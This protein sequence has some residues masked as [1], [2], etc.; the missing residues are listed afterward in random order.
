MRV[1]GVLLC[2]IAAAMALQPPPARPVAGRRGRA[3]LGVS[4]IEGALASG[5]ADRVVAAL[6]EDN[7]ETTLGRGLAAACLDKACAVEAASDGQS[8]ATALASEED[9][10]LRCYVAL[11]ERGLCGRFG[12]GIL[13][14]WPVTRRV[15]TPEFIAARTGNLTLASFAPTETVGPLWWVLGSILSVGEILLS[16]ALGLESPQP[17]FLATAGLVV[18]DQIA[19]R[20]AGSEAVV[21]TVST[22]FDERVVRHEAGHVLLAY[23][24]G[25]PVQGCCLSA[26]EAL[27]GADRPAALNGA[28]GTAFFDPDLNAAARRGEV[29]RGVL[30]RYC[31]I[32]MGGI[33]AEAMVYG[34]AQGGRDDEST[35]IQFLQQTVGGFTASNRGED[36]AELVAN[37]ARWAALNALLLLRKYRPEY[38]RLVEALVQ[39][40]AASIG[41]VMLAIDSDDA[42]A[43]TA[44]ARPA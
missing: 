23:L 5:S 30:D 43:P 6:E 29:R 27:L 7:D 12:A 34:D 3:A 11:R 17:L 4:P 20:G 16:K 1:S 42:A 39:T 14:P 15:V 38:E 31:I 10:L 24:L 8:G 32:V 13:E 36:P 35:L 28:A 25:C 40:R 19:L 33:A 22:D 41:T 18:L 9:R 2:F 44:V 37:Q 26:R 21:A